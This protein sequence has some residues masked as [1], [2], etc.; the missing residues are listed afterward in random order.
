MRERRRHQRVQTRT[1]AKIILDCFTAV[2]CVICDRSE[3][4]VRLEV[5]G[6]E[7]VPETFDLL[8][9][10]LD[11]FRTCHVVWR[12]RGLVGASFQ[13]W[14]SAKSEPPADAAHQHSTQAA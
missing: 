3:G 11:G 9:E 8:V 6:A 10:S 12:A 2:D 4:G 5:R 14:W 1:P 13:W 7:S